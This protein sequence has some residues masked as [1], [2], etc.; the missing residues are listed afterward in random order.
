[1]RDETLAL[2]DEFAAAWARGETPDPRELVDRA[3]EGEREEF[4]RMLDRYLSAAP[5]RE[6]SAASLEYMRSIASEADAVAEP[7]LLALRLERRLTRDAVVERLIGLLGLDPG[8]RA[9]VRRY[10]SDLEVGVLDPKGVAPELWSALRTVLSVDASGEWLAR[11]VT[12]VS[13][14]A[15]VFHRMADRPDLAAP[16]A[17]PPALPAEPAEPAEPDEVDRLFTGGRS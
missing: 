12:G 11:Q 4:R 9:K 13:L 10:F 14:S 5:A 8:K 2:L 7:P 3:A 1:M 17:V 15:P 16:A 6:V